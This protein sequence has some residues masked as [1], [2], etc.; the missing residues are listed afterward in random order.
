MKVLYGKKLDQD[1]VK[2]QCKSGKKIAEI[3]LGDRILIH[4]YFF[5][6]SYIAYVDIQRMYMRVAGGEFGEFP[7]DEYSLMIEDREGNEHALHVD[8]PEYIREILKW[9][10][11][12]QKEIQI[13]K[14]KGK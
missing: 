2:V 13:G 11:A 5:R 6:T 9:I 3:I 1:F 8:R 10:N 7:I 12:Y 4:K 14:E